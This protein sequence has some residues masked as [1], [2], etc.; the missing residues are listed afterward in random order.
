MI[1]PAILQPARDAG[2]GTVLS[3]PVSPATLTQA[4]AR[5]LGARE[6][7]TVAPPGT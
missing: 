1:D 4:I 2:L 6:E 7:T 3:K 5:L